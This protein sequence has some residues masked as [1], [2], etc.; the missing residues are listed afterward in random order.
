MA[1]AMMASYKAA[2]TSRVAKCATEDVWILSESTCALIYA[3]LRKRWH[4]GIGFYMDQ[5]FADLVE[6]PVFFFPVKI[7]GLPVKF[8]E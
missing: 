4:K 5:T 3:V 2:S 7:F 8:F 6:I 1:L